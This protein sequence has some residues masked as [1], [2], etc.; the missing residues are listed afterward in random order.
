MMALNSTGR[1]LATSDLAGVRVWDVAT[2]RVIHTCPIMKR[3]P[4]DHAKG[5]VAEALA[6]TPDGSRLATG[7][8]AGTV[9]F[10]PVPNPPLAPAMA[11][12]LP[13]LW[14]DLAGPDAGKGWRAAWRLMDDPAAAVKLIRTNLKPVERVPAADVARLLAD[15]DA[16]DFRRR[17]AATRRLMAIAD[18]AL[19]AV[20]EAAKA[21][22]DSAELRERLGKVLDAAPGD[23]RPPLPWAA[24]H[25]RAVALLEH[26]HTSDG[27]AALRDLAAGPPGA[28]LTREARAARARAAPPAR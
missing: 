2:G 8:P 10:W 26:I 21:A 24:A 1:V 23:E 12:E 14:A 6:F 16:S 17:E 20:T 13:G 28:W 27:T 22:G 19:P 9:L 11:G 5:R 3:P 25:S 4:L 18:Q 15:A 7:M